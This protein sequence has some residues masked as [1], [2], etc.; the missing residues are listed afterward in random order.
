MKSKMS[1][2]QYNYRPIA[3][4]LKKLTEQANSTSREVSLG[5]GLDHG[6]V[7]RFINGEGRPG[8]GACIQLAVF[9]DINPNEL[10]GLAGYELMPIFDLSLTDPNEF[11]P[12][13]KRVAKALTDITDA[14]VRQRVCKAIMILLNEHEDLVR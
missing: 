2:T 5:A 7:S 14:P 9:F 1:R 10:L 12:E 8:R 13:V 3:E 4:R 11:P 6:A